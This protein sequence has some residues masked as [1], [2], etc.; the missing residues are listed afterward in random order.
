MLFYRSPKKPEKW[1]EPIKDERPP[2]QPIKLRVSMIIHNPVVKSAGGIKLN[3]YMKWNDPDRIARQYI[4]D[5][6]KCSRGAAQYSI[7][8]RIEVADYPPKKDGFRYNED[9]YLQCWKNK[10]GFHRPDLIDYLHLLDRFDIIKKIE[11]DEIDEVWHFAFPCSGDYESIMAGRG[12]IWCNSPPLKGTEH[13]RRRFIIMNCNYERDVDCL[14]ENFGHRIESIMKHIYRRHRGKRN[15]WK[16]FT[17]YDKIAPGKAECGNVHF[18]PNSE[19]DYDWG[20]RRTVLSGADSWYLFPD[21][22]T[23]PRPMTCEEWGGGNMRLHHLWWLSH[24]PG[25]E[26]IT[27]GVSN[28]WWEYI[29]KPELIR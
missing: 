19:K 11:R 1:P 4:E 9:L 18:A 14:L 10:E 3:K 25:V 27:D 13:C 8:E 28:N 24:L 12:A 5:L 7:R 2:S 22:S 6:K 17:L 15:L 20:N 21:L 29:L 23:P 16:R 26:G